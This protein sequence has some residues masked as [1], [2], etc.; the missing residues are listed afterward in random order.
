MVKDKSSDPGFADPFGFDS[1]LL[2]ERKDSLYIW[3]LETFSTLY[4]LEKMSEI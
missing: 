2:S 1:V 3:K 4:F